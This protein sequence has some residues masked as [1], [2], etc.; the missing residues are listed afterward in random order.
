MIFVLPG[1][2]RGENSD[3]PEFD[4]LLNEN[5]LFSSFQGLQHDTKMV[6]K[7]P[8][9][10]KKSRARTEKREKYADDR[11]GTVR[12]RSCAD[13]CP[14]GG[15]RQSA[16]AIR[17]DRPDL[18]FPRFRLDFRARGLRNLGFGSNSRNQ[19]FWAR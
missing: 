12:E 1:G 7:R 14:P 6:P 10:R 19:R 2:V 17:P 8:E 16:A 11:P 15:G 13:R 9:R 3:K 4:D 5:A 18:L